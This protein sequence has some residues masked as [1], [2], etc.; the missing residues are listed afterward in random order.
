M[1][2]KSKFSDAVNG[3]IKTELFGV[4]AEAGDYDNPTI[5]WIKSHS[6]YLSGFTMQKLSRSLNEMVEMGIIGKGK[7]KNGRMV[8][9][10][11]TEYNDTTDYFV[12]QIRRDD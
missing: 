11:M 10:L 7:L 6:I 3:Q 12:K 2:K 9:R 1:Y 8:Y 5:D 4:L